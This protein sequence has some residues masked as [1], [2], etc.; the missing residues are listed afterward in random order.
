MNLP[1]VLTKYGL[2]YAAAR[3]QGIKRKFA[4]FWGTDA[5]QYGLGWKRGS[6]PEMDRVHRDGSA[7]FEALER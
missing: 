6:A 4:P 3:L 5:V 1:Y 7:H 2:V